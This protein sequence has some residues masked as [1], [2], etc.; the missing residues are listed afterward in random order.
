M[1]IC[2]SVNAFPGWPLALCRVFE[3]FKDMDTL[4]TMVIIDRIY[5]CVTD[6]LAGDIANYTYVG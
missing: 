6:W 5:C 2:N 4:G 3:H 1:Y